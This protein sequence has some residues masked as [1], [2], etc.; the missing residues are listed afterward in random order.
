[1]SSVITFLCIVFFLNSQILAQNKVYNNR[2]GITVKVDYSNLSEFPVQVGIFNND[3]VKIYK[4]T[5]KGSQKE[6]ISKLED[7]K[8]DSFEVMAIIEG[9][10]NFSFSKI[11]GNEVHLITDSNEAFGIFWYSKSKIIKYSVWIVTKVHFLNK[12][13]ICWAIPLELKHGEEVEVVLDWNN[14]FDLYE[15]FEELIFE[16]E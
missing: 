15:I 6:I 2:T 11:Q 9:C 3:P 8:L 16:S 10:W 4:K 12:V 5:I 1:M 14:V 7:N 13:P